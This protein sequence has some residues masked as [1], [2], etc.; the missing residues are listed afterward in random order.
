VSKRYDKG[1]YP[2]SQWQ[3]LLQMLD[4]AAEFTT[5]QIVFKK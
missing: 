5:M 1:D 3:D 4:A 2:A